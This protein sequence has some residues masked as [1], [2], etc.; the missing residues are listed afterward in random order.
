[1]RHTKLVTVCNYYE[2][3][4]VPDVVPQLEQL[5]LL[6]PQQ[7]PAC[8][9]VDHKASGYLNRVTFVFS[10]G[11]RSPPEDTYRDEPD[12]KVTLEAPLFSIVFG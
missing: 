10:E 7:L 3:N 4:K 8:W 9:Q 2:P 12:R 5:V 6:S 1:M 11:S